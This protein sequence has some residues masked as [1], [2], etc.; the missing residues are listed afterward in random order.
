MDSRLSLTGQ[1]DG[2]PTLPPTGHL[3]ATASQLPGEDPGELSPDRGT[4]PGQV[5]L[6]ANVR[7]K[8]VKFDPLIEMMVDQLPVPPP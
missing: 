3:G 7:R 6:F 5:I 8:M 1:G 2:A 4:L